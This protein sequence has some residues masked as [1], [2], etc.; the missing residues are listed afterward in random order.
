[1]LSFDGSVN[2]DVEFNTEIFR[3]VEAVQTEAKY[4]PVLIKRKY[5]Q[6]K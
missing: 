5:T 2:K 4:T 1:M 3:N 6:I